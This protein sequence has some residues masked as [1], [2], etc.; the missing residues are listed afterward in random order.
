LF[1]LESLRISQ[2]LNTP[3]YTVPNRPPMKGARFKRPIPADE[4]LYGG[5]VKYTL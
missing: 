5:Y 3:P 4:K 2:S 1:L